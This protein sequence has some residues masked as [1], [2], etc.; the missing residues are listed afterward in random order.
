MTSALVDKAGSHVCHGEDGADMSLDRLLPADAAALDDE[1]LAELIS[2]DGL[3]RRRRSLPTTLDRYL[4]VEPRLRSRLLPLDAAI[5]AV[6]CG[7]CASG[8]PG[9]GD[10]EALEREYPDLREPIRE[11][12][13]LTRAICS[14]L[15]LEAIE[16]RSRAVPCDFGP[17]LEDGL[18]RYRLVREISRGSSAFVYAAEDR[19]LSDRGRAAIVAVKVL[20]RR[21]PALVAVLAEEAGKARRVD[22]PNVVRALDRG[23]TTEGEPYLVYEMVDGGDLHEWAKRKLPLDPIGAASLIA[24]IAEGVHAAHL[25]GLVHCDLKP[26]NVLLTSAGEPK[27]ADFGIA[28]RGD[29]DSGARWRAYIRGNLGFMSPEQLDESGAKVSA[30][31]DVYSIGGLLYFLLTGQAPNGSTPDEAVRHLTNAAGD[32]VAVGLRALP[33][34]VPRE[35]DMICR[36]ALATRPEERHSSAAELA[37]DLRSFQAHRPIEWTRP[38]PAKRLLLWSRRRPLAASMIGVM[39]V[40]ITLLIAAGVRAAILEETAQRVK[41][42]QETFSSFDS[43]QKALGRDVYEAEHLT[44]LWAVEWIGGANELIDISMWR[45]KARDKRIEVVERIIDEAHSQGR[46]EDFETLLWELSVAFWRLTDKQPHAGSESELTEIRARLSERLRPGDALLHQ[47]D[48]MIAAATVKRHSI[49][50]VRDGKRP[51][52]EAL[53]EIEAAASVLCA[54]LGII[55]RDRPG[56]PAHLIILRA[57]DRAYRKPLLN[58]PAD[59]AWIRAQQK[60]FESGRLS[61]QPPPTSS[62]GQ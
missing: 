52:A 19:L 51:N 38:S 17:A 59:E 5:E 10:V 33:S 54:Q 49:A 45:D 7:R 29:E 15:E 47:V 58:R 36:R 26:Q 8:R 32:P 40:L 30:L 37:H 3:N 1:S 57:L 12:A 50:A 23:Q 41:R 27:V 35:L 6:L 34:R 39:G 14:T 56:S 20:G 28:R 24:R 21:D 2:E 62:S 43:Y 44:F 22:H 4:R 60:R 46:G 11:A 13:A 55:G 53:R 18:A 16:P 25:A 9:P 31:S 61:N 48:A 42:F